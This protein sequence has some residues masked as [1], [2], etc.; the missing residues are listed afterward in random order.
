MNTYM[1]TFE[2]KFCFIFI[3]VWVFIFIGRTNPQLYSQPFLVS[4]YGVKI[5]HWEKSEK[6][7]AYRFGAYQDGKLNP[8]LSLN[9]YTQDFPYLKKIYLKYSKLNV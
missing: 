2:I 1:N 3:S 6:L 7:E 4:L 8:R 9:S 5:K